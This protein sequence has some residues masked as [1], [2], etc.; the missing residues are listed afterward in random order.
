VT[1]GQIRFQSPLPGGA[2]AAV[3]ALALAGCMGQP[4]GDPPVH[5]ITDMDWQPKYRP[6]AESAF[7]ANG[8]AMRTPVEGTVSQTAYNPDD[9]YYSGARDGALVAVAPVR[10]TEEVLTRGQERFNIYC[11]PC[12]DR[13]G[14]G[15]GTAVQRGFPLPVNLASDRVRDMADGE[16]FQVISNGVRNMP[17]YRFQVPVEDRWA[18][19]T[20][21]RVL[22]RSQHATVADV[23]AGMADRIE[24][25]GN[26]P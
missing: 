19:I 14:S 24:P 25:E 15:Q 11:T 4:S 21:V 17:A 1:I 12:H 10:L 8:M 26:T 7:F 9:P 16:I 18:I 13:T 20:W 5:V 3:L 2:V 22:E 23:P 6:E